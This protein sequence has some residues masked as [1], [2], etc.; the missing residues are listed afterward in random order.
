MLV[1]AYPFGDPDDPRNFHKT[2]GVMYLVIV[3]WRTMK[4]LKHVFHHGLECWV[5][6]EDPHCGLFD[7][8]TYFYFTWMQGFDFPNFRQKSFR[9]TQ[10][11]FPDIYILQNLCF[12]EGQLS[13]MACM[14]ISVGV[15]W[16]VQTTRPTL[17]DTK[18]FF[19]EN[20]FFYFPCWGRFDYA[21]LQKTR[22]NCS[23][24]WVDPLFTEDK[25]GWNKGT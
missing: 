25:H 18:R 13:F 9:G 15:E 11:R 3:T 19:F 22:E 14:G 1:G 6:S 16:L 21:T 7:S 5:F 10:D 17:F 8:W 4:D 23:H 12:V 2:I 20:L 24:F